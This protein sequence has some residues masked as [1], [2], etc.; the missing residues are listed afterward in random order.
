MEPKKNILKHTHVA[1]E[2]RSLERSDQALTHNHVGFLTGDI[3]S[4]KDDFART[5]GIRSHNHIEHRGLSCTIGADEPNDFS[6]FYG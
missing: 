4:T 1:E 3:L 6:P 5:G 2:D